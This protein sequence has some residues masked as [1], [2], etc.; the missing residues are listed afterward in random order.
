MF[1]E[2]LINFNPKVKFS[3]SF[4]DFDFDFDF[5]NCFDEKIQHF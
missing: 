4:F 2:Q 1:I 5:L 3:Q